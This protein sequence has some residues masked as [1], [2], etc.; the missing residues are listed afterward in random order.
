MPHSEAY[1]D[2]GTPEEQSRRQFMANAV[3]VMGGA[4]G[5]AIAIPVLTSLIPADAT[6]DAAW[7]PLSPDEYAKLQK[8]TDQPIK[9]SFSVHETDG[10]FPAADVD[11]FVWAIKT[12]EEAMQKA[13]PDLFSGPT[14]L[15][16]D[17]VVMNF[18][19]FSPI[20]PHLGCRYTWFQDQKKFICP[21]HGSEYSE[22]GTHEAGPA[23]RGLDPLPLQFK[24][25]D[26]QV[27]WIEYKQNTP[28]HII[29][30]VA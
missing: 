5:L 16:Y 26:A 27:T 22:L 6:G 11:Q 19:V 1:K 28:D 17:P 3:V 23:P 13:R 12:S 8:V 2:P 29:L 18:T 30:R 25:G 20:C 21:C 4:I 24:G 7:S 10:Y 9:I 15:P 14:K